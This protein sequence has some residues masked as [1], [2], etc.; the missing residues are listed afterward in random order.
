MFRLKSGYLVARL[1][2]IFKDEKGQSITEYGLI[3]ALVAVGVIV[4]LGSI[5]TTLVKILEQLWDRLLEVA[6]WSA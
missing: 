4:L 3:I 1:R 5:G 6:G 2:T